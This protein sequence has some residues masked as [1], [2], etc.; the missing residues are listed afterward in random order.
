M[1]LKLGGNCPGFKLGEEQKFI[2][3]LVK[4]I[5][6]ISVKTS[7]ILNWHPVHDLSNAYLRKRLGTVSLFLLD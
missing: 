2:V 4:R 6:N 7:D 3:L 1:N 5:I